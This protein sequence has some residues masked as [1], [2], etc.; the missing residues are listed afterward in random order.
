MPLAIW[1]FVWK[2]NG[3]HTYEWTIMKIARDTTAKHQ[4]RDE[5]AE[6]NGN[7]TCTIDIKKVAAGL[8]IT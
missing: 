1:I 3:L 7:D 5:N 2:R 6:R 4:E 8:G